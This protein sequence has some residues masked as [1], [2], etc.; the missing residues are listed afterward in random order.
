VPKASECVN[1]LTPTCP[2][3][4]Y[5][6]YGAIRL[7]WTFMVMGQSVATAAVM[8]MDSGL[9][10]QQLDYQKLKVRLEKDAQVLNVP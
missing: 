10:V 9:P 8:A 4:S 6:A 5:V 7:E 1:L 3:S 2:S